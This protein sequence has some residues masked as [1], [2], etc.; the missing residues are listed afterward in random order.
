MPN[1]R[2]VSA[3]SRSSW[4]VVREIG[5]GGVVVVTVCV[6]ACVVVAV[7]PKLLG[8]VCR[9][10]RMPASVLRPRAAMKP[11]KCDLS[12]RGESGRACSI[13][14]IR[15][16]RTVCAVSSEACAACASALPYA[17]A[18][19]ALST[20]SSMVMSRSLVASCFFLSAGV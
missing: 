15:S 10:S 14:T 17:C 19:C 20:G 7:V 13:C 9:A 2:H 8:R 1:I 5:R 18:L 11:L 4:I 3:L 6:L 12:G 16:I